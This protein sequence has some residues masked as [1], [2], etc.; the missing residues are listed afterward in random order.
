MA[1]TWNTG[2]L[3]ERD[4]VYLDE[5]ANPECGSF[6]DINESYRNSKSIPAA[7]R[8]CSIFGAWIG[9]RNSFPAQL[10]FEPSSLIFSHLS[11]NGHQ[12]SPGIIACVLSISI[13]QTALLTHFVSLYRRIGGIGEDDHESQCRDAECKPVFSY[14]NIK[15]GTL[16][17]L[18]FSSLIIGF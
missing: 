4:D 10:K 16:I 6:P 17:I 5:A 7:Q 8:E 15:W 13:Y 2:L 1:D 3:P 9:A 11:L 14:G 18:A 12:L